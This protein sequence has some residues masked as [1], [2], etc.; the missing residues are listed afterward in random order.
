MA[1]SPS[2]FANNIALKGKMRT[3]SAKTFS[4]E[5]KIKISYDNH[6]NSKTFSMHFESSRK[7]T[8]MS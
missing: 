1:N 4:K 3:K 8:K 5:E 2:F 7:L 6:S